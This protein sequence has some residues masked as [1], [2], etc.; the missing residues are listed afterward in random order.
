MRKAL[1]FATACC[2]ATSAMAE[3]SLNSALLAKSGNDSWK[4]TTS[5]GEKTGMSRAADNA[6]AADGSVVDGSV[7]APFTLN[8]GE[9][10]VPAAAGK[11][12]FEY[13]PAKK[14]YLHITSDS[15]LAGGQVKVYMNKLNASSGNNAK[16][17]SEVGSYQ[18]RTEMASTSYTYYIVVDKL[19]ATDAADTFTAKMEDYQPGETEDTPITIAGDNTSVTLPGAVGTYFYAIDVP[20]NSNKFL[21]VEAQNDLSAESSVMLYA[22]GASTWN[23]PTMKD[24]VLKSSVNNATDA[25]YILK[26]ESNEQSPLSFKISYED[27][28]QGALITDPKEAVTGDN[29][30]NLSDTEYFSYTATKEGKLA[31][32]VDD[33]VEVTFPAGTGKYDGYNDTYHK[34]NVYFI[35]A[36]AGSKYLIAISGASKGATFKLEET[37]FLPGEMRS[38]PIVMDGDT[39]T[40]EKDASTVW[41]QY[42]VKKGGVVEFS[43]DVPFSDGDF[44]GIAKN[45]DEAISM[46]DYDASDHPEYKGLLQVAARDVLYVQVMLHGD[47]AG[48]KIT[49]TERDAQD[50]ET[51]LKPFVLEMGQTL[52][53]PHASTKKPVWVRVTLPKGDSKFWLSHGNMSLMVYENAF[54]IKSDEGQNVQMS[55]VVMPDGTSAFEF[56]INVPQNNMTRWLKIMYTDGEPKLTYVDE[57]STGIAHIDANAD[58]KKSVYTIDGTKL[59][60]MKG[61]GVFIIKQNGKTRKVIVK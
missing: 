59:D 52:D 46:V 57:E 18:V 45:K 32:T 30:I 13:K 19:V 10:T 61:S 7:D 23:A 21:I 29:T 58:G 54:N 31:V 8:E 49:L 60:E 24:G 55:D 25:T 9:N 27:I 17:A 4:I 40:L 36:A 26:F 39:Y 3:T 22:K 53:V 1:L 50:G 48:K 47:M 6:S 5:T 38:N 16:G 11:Y 2:L 42:T 37:D 41:L 12:F 20:A 35:Q 14:G 15:K 43:C 56:K 44:I 28:E 33:G 51:Y 34:G